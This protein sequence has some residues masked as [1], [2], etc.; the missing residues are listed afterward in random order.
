M[1][2]CAPPAA[3][4]AAAPAPTA[5]SHAASIAAGGRI[6]GTFGIIRARAAA[7]R[8]PAGD[9]WTRPAG[10]GRGRIANGRRTAA[11]KGEILCAGQRRRSDRR[12]RDGHPK[13]EGN[14]KRAIASRHDVA[15]SPNGSARHTRRVTVRSSSGARL[16]GGK[17]PPATRQ[18]VKPAAFSS[19]CALLA[20]RPTASRLSTH[21]QALLRS[22][23]PPA[24]VRRRARKPPAARGRGSP[25]IPLRSAR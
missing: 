1:A 23:L 25:R 12:Q 13:S 20:H 14:P 6:G 3:S 16:S 21:S 24:R 11:S 17:A 2:R 19:A 9:C 7:R 4:A 22:A 15:P 8:P 18:V 5:A 10:V